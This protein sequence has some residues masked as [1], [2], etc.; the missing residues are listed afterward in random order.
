MEIC[1]FGLVPSVYREESYP[2]RVG[3]IIDRIDGI[4][5]IRGM[6]GM[7]C[8]SEKQVGQGWVVDGRQGKGRKAGG[9]GWVGWMGR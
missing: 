4:E 3:T 8:I 2:L 1:S 7:R 9:Q 5:G 6:K